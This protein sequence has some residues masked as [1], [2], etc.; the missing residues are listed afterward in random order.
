MKIRTRYTLLFTLTVGII[1]SFF[2][3]SIYYLSENYRKEDFYSR[4]QDRGIAKLKLV[5]ASDV[6]ASFSE[7]RNNPSTSIEDEKFIILNKN[8]HILFADSVTNKPSSSIINSITLEKPFYQSKGHEETIGFYYSYLGN[9]YYIFCSGIDIHGKDYINNL[10]KMLLLRGI[11]LLI[12]IFLSGWLIVGYFLKPISNIIEQVESISYT[13]ISL[14]LKRKYTEDEIGKLTSTFN[15]MLDRLE[16][17]FDTQKRFVANASH[18]LRNPLTAINGQIDVALMNERSNEDYKNTLQNIS[19][20]IKNLQVLTNN[21]LDL[22]NSEESREKQFTE[23]RIDELIWTARDFFQYVHPTYT[24]TISFQ[25][26]NVDETQLTCKGEVKLLERAFINLMDNA[27]KFSKNHSVD[28]YISTKNSFISL[29]FK[30][31]GIGIPKEQLHHIFEPMFRSE[32][33]RGIEGNGIGLSLVKKIIE[34]HGG[35]IHLDSEQNKGTT[36]SIQLKN[37]EKESF[38]NYI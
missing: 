38:Y 18:E 23:I 25:T 16:T 4:L 12:I 27:C 31:Q 26:S 22:A 30:D 19:K 7:L 13:N 24:V 9:G 33:A 21:L 36:I 5:I 3:F 35:S 29:E 32:N 11:L 1:L 14:R 37:M 20:D 28:I 2:S 34:L 17:S 10:Q 15:E 8:H 6:D